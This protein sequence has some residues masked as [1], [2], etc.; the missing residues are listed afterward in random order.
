M[1]LPSNKKLLAMNPEQFATWVKQGVN[2][3]EFNILFEGVQFVC[4][5]EIESFQAAEEQPLQEFVDEGSYL[6]AIAQI[7]P[8][9]AP[10]IRQA[11]DNKILETEE[12]NGILDIIS[13][14]YVS[15]I[16][17]KP[18]MTFNC[19]YPRTF[20]VSNSKN[21]AFWQWFRAH[22]PHDIKLTSLAQHDCP[23]ECFL[24]FIIASNPHDLQFYKVFCRE[25]KTRTPDIYEKIKIDSNTCKAIIKKQKEASA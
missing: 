1:K 10:L 16:S 24:P 12:Y 25:I 23:V 7:Y 8:D 19:L 21:H 9:I 20:I 5:K 4:Q 13:L 11:F 2:R 17:D 3:R 18:C 6:Y 15:S 14:I 22:L